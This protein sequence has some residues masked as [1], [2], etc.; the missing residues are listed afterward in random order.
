MSLSGTRHVSVVH[1]GYELVSSSLNW[2]ASLQV[3]AQKSGSLARVSN[4]DE[5]RQLTAFLQS[6]NVTQPVWIAGQVTTK[7]NG[8]SMGTAN[9]AN[10]NEYHHLFY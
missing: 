9:S 3:C 4:D 6:L 5:N 2:T 1:H 7:R 8:E 10:S